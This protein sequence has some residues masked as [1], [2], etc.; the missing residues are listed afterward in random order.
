MI[1]EQEQGYMRL[2]LTLAYEPAKYQNEQTVQ[3]N[4][5]FEETEFNQAL[6]HALSAF[7]AEIYWR[8]AY[9]DL[10]R[11]GIRCQFHHSQIPAVSLLA[12]QPIRRTSRLRSVIRQLFASRRE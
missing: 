3:I 2:R 6:N 12:E 11:R 5:P 8:M 9:A 7:S 10:V 4:L 1:D